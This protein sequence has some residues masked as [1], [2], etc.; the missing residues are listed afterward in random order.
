MEKS[1]VNISDPRTVS[2]RIFYAYSRKTERLKIK[3]IVVHI[4]K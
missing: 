1:C 4:H 2:E 3:V